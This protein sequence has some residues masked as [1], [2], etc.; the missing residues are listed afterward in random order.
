[1]VST[2]GKTVYGTN[3]GIGPGTRQVGGYISDASLQQLSRDISGIALRAGN[4]NL[5]KELQ[6]RSEPKNATK[7]N[8]VLDFRERDQGSQITPPAPDSEHMYV[9]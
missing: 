7:A 4:E 9:P 8:P 1:M 3:R 6:T 5:P 2:N